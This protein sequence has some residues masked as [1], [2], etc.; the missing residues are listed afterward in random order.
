MLD[1]GRRTCLGAQGPRMGADQKHG[2]RRQQKEGAHG[3]ALGWEVPGRVEG[4]SSGADEQTVMN[5]A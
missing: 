4:L 1:G 3:G 2:Q 5:A